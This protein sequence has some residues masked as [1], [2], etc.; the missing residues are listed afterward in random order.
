MNQQLLGAS[1]HKQTNE[2]KTVQIVCLNM[3]I[4]QSIRWKETKSIVEN[5]SSRIH[6]MSLVDT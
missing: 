3:D 6:R 1:F 2:N 4:E 5:K